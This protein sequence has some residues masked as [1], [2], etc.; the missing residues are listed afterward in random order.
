MT[1]PE[2]VRRDLV[3]RLHR[4][5]DEDGLA[6]GD[7][8]AD[9]DEG[10]L[11]R[12]GRAIGGADHRRGQGAGVGRKVF[13]GGWGRGRHGAGRRGRRLERGGRRRRCCGA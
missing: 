5:D 4:F 9:V 7:L 1:V 10:G 12:L 3:H 11:A 13:G 2:R 6:L 8:R